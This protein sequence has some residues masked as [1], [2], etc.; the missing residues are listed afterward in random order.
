MEAID[1]LPP[2]EPGESAIKYTLPPKTK[3]QKE[4]RNGNDE[5]KLHVATKHTEKMLE[6]IKHAGKNINCIPKEL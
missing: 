3:Y 4:R 1:D 6:I 5:L 2:I